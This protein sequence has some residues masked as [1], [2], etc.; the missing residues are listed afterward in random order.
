MTPKPAWA[1]L[2]TVQLG[3]FALLGKLVDPASVG[4]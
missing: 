1:T 3:R 2:L 4:A